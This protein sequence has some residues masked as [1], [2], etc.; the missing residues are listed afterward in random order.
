MNEKQFAG[1]IATICF[2]ICELLDKAQKLTGKTLSIDQRRALIKRLK[3]MLV[4]R[5]KPGPKG[6]ITRRARHDYNFNAIRGNEL[7]R[8]HI[9]GFDAL[10]KEIKEEKKEKLINNIHKQNSRERQRRRKRSRPQRR[11]SVMRKPKT[12]S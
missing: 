5:Q 11:V 12:H 8:K 2:T 10:P 9:P 3:A 7:C 4:P 6:D 1:L